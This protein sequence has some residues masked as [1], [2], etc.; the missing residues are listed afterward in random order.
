MLRRLSGWVLSGVLAVLPNVWPA[1]ASAAGEWQA[2]AAKATFQLPAGV[3]LAGYSRRGGEPSRGVHDPVGV[4]AL[5]VTDHALTVAIVSCDLLII[6]ER[7]F[8]AVNERLAAA[9]AS[10]PDALLLAAT[11]THSGP[12]A[13]G[14]KFLEKLSM[15]HF[16]PQVF[17]RI[18]DQI[19]ATIHA[20]YARRQ[21]VRVS[22]GR[23]AAERLVTNR[24]NPD[25]AVDAELIVW[26]FDGAGEDPLAVLVNFSAHPTTLGAWNRQLSADYP[27]VIVRLIEARWPATTGMFLVGAVGDQAPVVKGSHYARAEWIGTKLA[28][29]AMAL[30]EQR[31]PVIPA[32][33]LAV[34]Q[35]VV[36][37]PPARLRLGRVHLPRWM[38]RWFVDDDATLSLIS[39]GEAVWIGV[40]CDLVASFGQRLKATARAQ[41]WE[42]MIVGFANDYIGYC[43]PASLYEAD[44]YE[45]TL[46]FNGPRAGERIVE[47]L[48]HMI[49]EFGA[50]SEPAPGEP[51]GQGAQ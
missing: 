45:A 11:H 43:I 46:A 10:A 32:G 4:R 30:V 16:D 40:P 31:I 1:P 37:L 12:G 50:S 6:D 26:A 21:H 51:G 9:G 49:Q 36:P 24:M 47:R 28:E 23:I 3:P 33:G 2:G 27:G 22:H 18:V 35:A 42:P 5:V 29:Q 20:A 44:A 19:V 14:Q 25:G 7:V 15:G 41:G 13:Y 8:Q 48:E 17:E 39:M 34:R 38:S